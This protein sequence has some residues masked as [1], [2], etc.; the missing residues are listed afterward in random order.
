MTRTTKQPPATATAPVGPSA[1]DAERPRYRVWPRA[2][3]VALLVAVGAL[4]IAAAAGEDAC[5]DPRSSND[6]DVVRAAEAIE[7][8]PALCVARKTFEENGIA[9][10]LTTVRN[11]ERPGPLWVV[12]HDEED[13]AFLAGIAAVRE[14]GGAMIAVE[15]REGRMI[16]GRDPNRLFAL[17]EAAAAVCAIP[18]APLYIAAHFAEWDRA[19]PVIG[20]HTNWDGHVGAAGQGTI[21][22]LRPDVKM[23]PFPSASATGRFADEDTVVMLPGLHPPG[24]D[25]ALSAAVAW[26][27][28]RGVHVVVRLITAQNNECTIADFL[29]LGGIAPYV[30]IEVEFGDLDTEKALVDLVWDYF[31][32]GPGSAAGGMGG[33]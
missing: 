11:V 9:W 16:A 8:A 18:A 26:F 5:L 21:S 17:S 13:A 22:I 24:E 30:N 6:A 3:A 20:L 28:S 1:R 29:T 7:A 33:P 10:R 19:F 2:V 23:V 25:V 14:R 12:P 27:N 15:N 4:P 31:T 32:V